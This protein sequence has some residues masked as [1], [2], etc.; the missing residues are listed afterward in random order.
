MSQ[1]TDSDPAVP[2]E[3][4]LQAASVPVLTRENATILFDMLPSM[5][6]N[7]SAE[8]WSSVHRIL[9][10]NRSEEKA[11]EEKFEEETHQLAAPI[12]FLFLSFMFGGK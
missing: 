12:L 10:G 6:S 8:Q 1:F 5:V 9:M 7:F 11:A 3:D 2:G 4:L